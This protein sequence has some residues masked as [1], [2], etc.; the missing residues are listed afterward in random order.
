MK[1]IFLAGFS[2][3]L[4]LTGCATDNEFEGENGGV[5]SKDG[6][7]YMTVRISDVQG[8]RATSGGFD[9][10]KDASE[11]N[12]ASADFYFYDEG[13]IF[14]TRAN[15]WNGGEE[16]SGEGNN[17]EFNGKTVVA[18]KGLTSKGFPK[19]VVTVLNRPDGFEPGKTLTE[20]GQLLSVEGAVDG[21]Y[22]TGDNFIMSTSSYIHADGTPNF[23]TELVEDNFVN[24]PGSIDPAK[25]VTIYVERLAAKVKIGVT[26]NAEGATSPLVPVSGKPDTYEM[27]M[28][29]AGDPNA[30]GS[31]S[32]IGSQTIHVHFLGWALTGTA[33][34]SLMMKDIKAWTDTELGFSWNDEFNKRSYWGMSFNYDDAAYTYRSQANPTAAA[35]DALTYTSY[36]DA[37]Q[38]GALRY[39]MSDAIYCAENTNTSTIVSGNPAGT[40]TS[41]LLFA[42]VTDTDG[43]ALDLVRYHGVFYE[44]ARYIAYVFD[45]LNKAASLNYYKKDGS[46]YTQIGTG[47]AEINDL[48]GGY[49]NVRLTLATDTPLYAKNG[50]DYALIDAKDGKTAVEQVN[51]KLSGFNTEGDNAIGYKGG[52]M[53]YNIAIE[54]LNDAGKADVT[55]TNVPEAVYGIVRNHVYMLNITSLSNLG[56]G[57]FDPDEV[58]IPDNP[59]EEKELYQVGADIKI[60]SWKV[61]NQDVEL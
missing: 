46:T 11:H 56:M 24:D 22:K 18:L 36:T 27:K 5:V 23:V 7:A 29:I 25:V 3:A 12:V 17:V 57:I 38:D 58:I 8:T 52:L 32:N 40:L 10:S 9:Q 47:D 55:E 53:Y 51:E 26:V 42:E 34:K 30:A 2:A 61:V 14:V 15:V 31:G 13:G 33:K 35:T 21:G 54:H 48:D 4:A 20:M 1:R 49:V 60:L 50:E 16:N 45:N 28:T 43:T 6:V 39:G 37:L 59:F 19:Y 41:V 44:E